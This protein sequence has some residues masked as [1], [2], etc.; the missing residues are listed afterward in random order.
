MLKIVLLIICFLAAVRA[1]RTN[2]RKRGLI[3]ME[4]IPDGLSKAQWEDMKRKEQENLKGKNLGAVGITKF[5]SRS[6]ESFQKS[7]AK[8]LFP[9]GP[10]TPLDQRPYM[11][12]GGYS[13]FLSRAPLLFLTTNTHSDL[14]VHLMVKI[15]KRKDSLG[16][17]RGHFKRRPR[18]MKST[19]NFKIK[20]NWRQHLGLKTYLGLM[21][22]LQHTNRLQMLL[23]L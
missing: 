4:Y 15:S 20:A 3:A 9:V 16:S 12:V 10:D 14:E 18:S 6:F 13:T 8:N 19:K 21:L 1:F 17:A 11:Q 2:I 23:K 22:K 5:K 7:G